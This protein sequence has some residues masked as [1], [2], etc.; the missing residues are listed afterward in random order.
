MIVPGSQEAIK[1]GCTCS[2]TDNN[3]GRG[4]HQRGGKPV[5]YLNETCPIHGHGLG[6]RSC[7][8]GSPREQEHK[9]E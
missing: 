4:H 3:H 1:R 6:C 9:K 5:F 8:D 7:G 2:P